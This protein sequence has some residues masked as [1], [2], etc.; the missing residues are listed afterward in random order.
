VVTTPKSKIA[1]RHDE[2]TLARSAASALRK[3]P[4]ASSV[5]HAY[6]STILAKTT[7]VSG[8]KPSVGGD[9]ISLLCFAAEL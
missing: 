3:I 5:R 9:D 6:C 2:V 7:R 4:M 8:L 1:S